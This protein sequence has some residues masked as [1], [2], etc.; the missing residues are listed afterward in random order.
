MAT[1]TEDR[2]MATP[3]RSKVRL[4]AFRSGRRSVHA[5]IPIP[6]FSKWRGK[7]ELFLRHVGAGRDSLAGGRFPVRHGPCGVSDGQPARSP[8]VVWIGSRRKTNRACWSE[9]AG[10]AVCP[11]IARM[12]DECLCGQL[13]TGP[14]SR[15]GCGVSMEKRFAFGSFRSRCAFSGL[16]AD[17]T[18]VAFTAIPALSYEHY[19]KTLNAPGR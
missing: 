11:R 16:V 10:L 7:P 1:S 14:P 8:S 9:P 3:G 13:A 15:G 4:S 6:R 5:G 2:W 18:R 12:A 19:L 17:G